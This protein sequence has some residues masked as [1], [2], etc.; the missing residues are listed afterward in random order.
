MSENNPEPEQSEGKPN[1]ARMVFF[2][3]AVI[4]FVWFCL[5]IALP[6]ISGQDGVAQK[7]QNDLQEDS[8]DGAPKR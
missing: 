2:A 1:D 4:A 8:R 7:M 5:F 3:I 6:A